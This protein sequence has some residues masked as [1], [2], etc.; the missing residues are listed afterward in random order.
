MHELSR[1]NF[2]IRINSYHWWQKIYIVH[3][4]KIWGCEQ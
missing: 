4:K 2:T 1:I 3:V